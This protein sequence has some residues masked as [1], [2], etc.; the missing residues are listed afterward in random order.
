MNRL[1]QYM[2]FVLMLTVTIALA[3]I[4][5]A[6]VS[7]NFVIELI[8]RTIVSYILVSIT[9]TVLLLIEISENVDG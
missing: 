4:W 7:D 3:E 2:G 6:P 9:V 1:N 8:A 5:Q